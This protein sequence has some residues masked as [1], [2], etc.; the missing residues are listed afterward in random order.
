MSDTSL[1]RSVFEKPVGFQRKCDTCVWRSGCKGYSAAVSITRLAS[2]MDANLTRAE[3]QQDDEVLARALSLKEEASTLGML[4]PDFQER[5]FRLWGNLVFCDARSG[6]AFSDISTLGSRGLNAV[7]ILMQA[8]ILRSKL[9]PGPVELR[10]S[11]SQYQAPSYS[12][13][14][15]S[16]ETPELQRKEELA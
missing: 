16:P 7:V 4:E 15:A 9:S 12:T 2:R 11:L 6:G 5:I 1:Q 14:S 8:D 10:T 13:S 3:N